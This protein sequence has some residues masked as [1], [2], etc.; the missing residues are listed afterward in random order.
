MRDDQEVLD[1]LLRNTGN[2]PHVIRGNFVWELPGI[3]TSGTA[4]TVLGAIINDWQLSGV[5]TERRGRGTT[6]P[7]RITPTVAT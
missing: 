5:Y 7:T 2:R 6:R 1:E 4:T 3:S